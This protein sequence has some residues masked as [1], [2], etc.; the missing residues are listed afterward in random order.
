MAQAANRREGGSAGRWIVSQYDFAV[1]GG[2]VGNIGLGLNLA[3]GETIVRSFAEVLTSP[4]SAGA[5]TLGVQANATD[6]IVAATVVSGAPWST[7]GYKAGVSDGLVANFK[8]CTAA[9]E[10]V[11]VV[12]VAALTAG[13]VNIYLEII[14][15]A[16][17]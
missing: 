12:G 17:A 10:V 7:T 16:V 11:M 2:A 5:A 13:K 8:K 3:T 1:Q 9:R 6:D 14:N 15:N 4:A